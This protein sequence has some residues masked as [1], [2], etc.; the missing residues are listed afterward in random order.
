MTHTPDR[1]EADEQRFK[2]NLDQIKA[3]GGVRSNRIAQ[4]LRTAF[5]ESTAELKEG[6]SAVT[7]ATEEVRKSVTQL[8]REKGQETLAE[9]KHVW[10]E[11]SRPRSPGWRGWFQAEIQAARRALKATLSKTRR[12]ARTPDKVIKSAEP[13]SVLDSQ[14][15]SNS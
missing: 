2:D 10:A 11:R 3:E 8:I 4:I 14:S 15:Q 9:A 13:R 7:P 5:A 6:V 1:P 12:P